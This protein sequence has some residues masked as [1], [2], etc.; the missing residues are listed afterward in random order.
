MKALVVIVAVAVAIA[1]V[2][3]WTPGAIGGAFILG[4]IV[5][6]ASIAALL[7]LGLALI[8]PRVKRSETA[9]R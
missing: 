6:T 7:S 1:A 4:A 9:V 2:T 5:V 3:S 8:G